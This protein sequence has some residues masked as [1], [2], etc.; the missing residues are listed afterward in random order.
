[1]N[2]YRRRQARTDEYLAGLSGGQKAVRVVLSVIGLVALNI[3][4]GL[5]FR[6]GIDWSGVVASALGFGLALALIVWR[7]SSRHS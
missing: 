2:W 5:I 4:V 6:D 3:G 1:M 7:L